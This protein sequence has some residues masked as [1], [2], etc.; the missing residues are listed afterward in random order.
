MVW[1]FGTWM[2]LG[3]A[4]EKAQKDN[5]VLLAMPILCVSNPALVG[6]FAALAFGAPRSPKRRCRAEEAE[7]EFEVRCERGGHHAGIS[8]FESRTY[9]S[10]TYV[11]P[12]K[13]QLLHI[14]DLRKLLPGLHTK[15]VCYF[16]VFAS[17]GREGEGEGVICSEN[18]CQLSFSLR[19]SKKTCVFEAGS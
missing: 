6:L 14:A 19:G 2:N 8:E 13:A 1:C 5:Q 11:Y 4:P 12:M 18:R 9:T 10:R 3:I 16:C 7:P 17:I 15:T